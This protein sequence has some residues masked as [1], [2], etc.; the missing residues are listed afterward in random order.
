MGYILFRKRKLTLK[1]GFSVKRFATIV[2]AEQKSMRFHEF[3][4]FCRDDIQE[5]EMLIFSFH[6]LATTVPAKLAPIILKSYSLKRKSFSTF[7][8]LYVHNSML[9]YY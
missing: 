6:G 1:G 9:Y 2:P 3:Y 8:V 7:D 5:T 4:M